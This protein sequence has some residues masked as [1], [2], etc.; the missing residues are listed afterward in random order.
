M[1]PRYPIDAGSVPSTEVWRPRSWQQNILTGPMKPSSPV[2]VKGLSDTGAPPAV[3][4]T[5]CIEQRGDSQA[6]VHG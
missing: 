4:G 2:L 6:V 3:T 1:A 5:V